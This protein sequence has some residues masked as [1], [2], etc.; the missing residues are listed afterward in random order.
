MKKPTYF[1]V[2]LVLSSVSYLWPLISFFGNKAKIE[3]GPT[4]NA[5]VDKMYKELGTFTSRLA[6]QNRNTL[7]LI[8]VLVSILLLAAVW[9]FLLKKDIVKAS[10]IYLGQLVLSLIYSVYVY[11][12]GS[13][14]LSIFTTDLGRQTGSFSL[15]LGLGIGIVMFL[16][17]AGI[18]LFKLFRY[19]NAKEEIAES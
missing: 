15:K 2:L 18:V 16:V 12:A 6:D 4:G 17:F 11:M 10:Y 7:S 8:I 13:A 5:D 3:Y 19:Q 14:L 9:F 1:Y